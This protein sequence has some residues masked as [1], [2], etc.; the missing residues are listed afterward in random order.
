M[1]KIASL[2]FAGT[3]IFG[4]TNAQILSEQN[5]TIN[6]DLQPVL[7]LEIE[8]PE[9][10]DFNFT[11]INQY[12]NGITR[13]GANVLKV[14]ASV[15]F[16]L[17][18]A[19]F[20][21]GLNSRSETVYWDNVSVYGND[22]SALATNS[23]PVS[24]LELH[25]FPANPSIGST[26]GNV[27]TLLTAD[28]DYSTAFQDPTQAPATGNNSIYFPVASTNPYLAPDD[29]TGQD[30]YIAGYAAQSAAANICAVSGGSYLSEDISTTA[31]TEPNAITRDGYYFVMDYRIVPGLPSRFPMSDPLNNSNRAAASH[32]SITVDDITIHGGAGTNALAYVKPGAYQMQ[33]KY[34]LVE[35]Q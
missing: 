24:A 26:C 32:A 4:S 23:I 16:D 33:I 12:I 28:A 29:A 17:W 19:G 9:V 35:D 27:G 14:S 11:E 20:S 8:G 31:T 1:K 5:V 10:I 13:Y 6:M 7:Q 18:A 25:Q 2:L 34:I 30:K 22:A 3:L 21:Q 15:S